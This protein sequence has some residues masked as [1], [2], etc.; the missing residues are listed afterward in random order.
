MV[1]TST[2]LDSGAKGGSA[3][4]HQKG[5]DK[6]TCFN[7]LVAS[8][9]LQKIGNNEKVGT[10][11]GSGPP[12]SLAAVVEPVLGSPPLFIDI[13]KGHTHTHKLVRSQFVSGT[14]WEHTAG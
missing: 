6:H 12:P 5:D 3:R 4:H 9:R 11:G 1:E 8:G 2:F 7:H 10:C 13:T 14:S